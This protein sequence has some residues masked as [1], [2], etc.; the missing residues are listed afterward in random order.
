MHGAV[1]ARDQ[2]HDS[3]RGKVRTFFF[4][5][6][7]VA[8]QTNRKNYTRAKFLVS[9]PSRNLHLVTNPNSTEAHPRPRYAPEKNTSH[10]SSRS[11]AIAFV[12][13]VGSCQ[14][15]LLPHPL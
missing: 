7:R 2:P 6:S 13:T 12:W 14:L 10:S 1:T 15:T 8:H 11:K 9:V 3:L 5:G 4:L